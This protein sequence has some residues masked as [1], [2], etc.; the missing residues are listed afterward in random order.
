MPVQKAFPRQLPV[1]SNESQRGGFADVAK[2]H[3]SD[4]GDRHQRANADAAINQA[5]SIERS[6]RREALAEVQRVAQENTRLKVSALPMGQP[7]HAL[8][9]WMNRRRNC[10]SCK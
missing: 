5:L 6:G 2:Q 3:R 8:V 10:M 7:T 1:Q 9:T 4:R